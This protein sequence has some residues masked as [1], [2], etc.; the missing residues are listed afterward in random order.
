M[1]TI[2]KVEDIEVWK[3]GVKLAID[4]VRF[5]NQ[6]G[7]TFGLKDQ[8]I[9][10]SISIASNVAEGFEYQSKKDF[11][12]FLRYARGSAAE[13]KTQ[14]IIIQANSTSKGELQ[15]YIDRCEILVKK[16]QK[17]TNYLTNEL[18]KVEQTN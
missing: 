16:L 1:G 2:R 10:S 11:I 9:R 3:E 13:L 5:A 17:F 6:E 12:R 7:L 18:N 14:L 4:V 8:I 15:E